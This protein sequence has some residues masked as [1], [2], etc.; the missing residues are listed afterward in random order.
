MLGMR[1]LMLLAAAGVVVPLAGWSWAELNA[2]QRLEPDTE[3]A[4]SKRDV[5]VADYA[6]YLSTVV[7]G[8]DVTTLVDQFRENCPDLMKDE[9]CA[10]WL[11]TAARYADDCNAVGKAMIDYEHPEDCMVEYVRTNTNEW[12]QA[13]QQQSA[14]AALI[15]D[16]AAACEWVRPTEVHDGEDDPLKGV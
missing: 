14:K 13:V 5:C 2:E 9:K 4:P 1:S 16:A 15:I 7:V 10:E 6:E 11:K 3:P 12:N 8:D